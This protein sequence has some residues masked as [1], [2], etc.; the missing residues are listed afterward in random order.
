MYKILLNGLQLSD[1]KSGVQ[2][3]TR[4][5]YCELKKNESRSVKFFLLNP[6][7]S[8][9]GFL[10]Y[11]RLERILFE[12]VLLPGYFRKNNFTLYH[13]PNYVLPFFFNFFSV[14]TVHD[15]ITFD[16]PELCQPESVIYFRLL[17]G[18]S[19]KKA[20]KIITVSETVK[21]DILKHFNISKN[22]ITVIYPGIN[23][24]FKKSIDLKTL[25]KYR[26]H[27]E[28]ILFVGNIEPKKNLVRLI[29]AFD[30]LIR[31]EKLNHK[32]VIVGKKGWKYRSVFQSVEDLKLKSRVI[33]TGYVPETDLPVLYS[34][35]DLFVFPS[36]YEGFGIPPLE[37]M[38][39][40]TP[41]LVSNCG[42]LPETTGGVCSQT[43]PYE[44]ANIS[45]E[46]YKLLSDKKYRSESVKRG[47]EWVKHFSWERAARETIGLYYRILKFAE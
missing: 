34:M 24:I 29:R 42:A 13:S 1:K 9:H 25:E 20:H 8:R 4:N 31:S 23:P 11:N 17:L 10:K 45:N 21:E 16:Y 47:K 30:L 40:E 26:I 5:L 46:M 18:R 6:P 41:V 3:Y 7:V 39:C 27:G 2:Y 35:A 12:N 15:L 36:L 43:D 44:I 22:K 33:F 38:A 14:L 32:L 19:V 37:A 28:Y